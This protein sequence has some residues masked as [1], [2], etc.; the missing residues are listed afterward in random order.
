MSDPWR[1]VYSTVF[2]EWSILLPLVVFGLMV[3]VLLTC[4]RE[5]RAAPELSTA[6]ILRPKVHVPFPFSIA[7]LSQLV[8]LLPWQLY[9]F[10]GIL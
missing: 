3:P 6:A 10:L 5:V 1:I 9:E 8:Q 7:L 4:I 2:G